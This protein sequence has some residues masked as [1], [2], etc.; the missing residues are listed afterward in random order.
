[1]FFFT[2]G[3]ILIAWGFQA[4]EPIDIQQTGNQLKATLDPT[5]VLLFMAGSFLVG[6]GVGEFDS[7]YTIYKLEKQIMEKSSIVPK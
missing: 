4:T 1:M 6:L 2:I 7:T 5:F 3:V